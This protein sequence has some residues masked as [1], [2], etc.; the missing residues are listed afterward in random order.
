MSNDN[1]PQKNLARFGFNSKLRADE[2]PPENMVIKCECG[3]RMIR[4]KQRIQKC[5]DCSKVIEN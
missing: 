1:D 5:P 2:R 3:A 4:L